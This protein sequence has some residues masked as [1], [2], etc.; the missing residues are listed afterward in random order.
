M[1]TLR[2]GESKRDNLKVSLEHDRMCAR[3]TEIGIEE[4]VVPPCPP[5][6]KFIAS[7]GQ[8]DDGMKQASCPLCRLLAAICNAPVHRR[9]RAKNEYHLRAFQSIHAS[10][11]RI[12]PK[13]SI[14][15]PGV[16][17]G[18][19]RG[20]KTQIRTIERQRCLTKG[21]VAPS[22]YLSS[23]DCS[24]PQFDFQVQ[25][26]RPKVASFAQVKQWLDICHRTHNGACRKATSDRPSNFKCIDTNNCEN[27]LPE[28]I[29]ADDEYLALSY[30]CSEAC[31]RQYC[32]Q[33]TD[34]SPPQIVPHVCQTIKDA[35]AVT[36][37][38]GFRYIWI[39]KYCIDQHNHPERRAAIAT[40]DQIYEGASMTLVAAPLPDSRPGLPGISRER[41]TSQPTV[42]IGKYLWV[43]T[44]PH[45]S[46]AIASTTWVTRGW[47]Y[48]E[49]VLS[50]RCLFFTDEQM[51]F[52]CQQGIASESITTPPDMELPSLGLRSFRSYALNTDLT[53]PRQP[54]QGLWQFF[55]D[56]YHYKRRDLSFDFDS[57][58]AFQGVLT[59]YEYKHIWGT[60]IVDKSQE[61]PA[62]EDIDLR[63]SFLRGLWWENPGHRSYN[64][65]PTDHKHSSFQ[66]RP[67]FPSWSWP[68]WKGPISPHK[69]NSDLSSD[70]ACNAISEQTPE[71]HLWFETVGGSLK[72]IEQTIDD[73]TLEINHTLRIGTTVYK[74]RIRRPTGTDRLPHICGCYNDRVRCD[75]RHTVEQ[76]LRL[77]YDPYLLEPPEE[78]FEKDWYVIRLFTVDDRSAA[79]NPTI[80]A[81]IVDWDGDSDH[82]A[83]VI[84]VA[85]LELHSLPA[86]A[87]AIV[88]LN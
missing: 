8:I 25:E 37:S 26:V 81:F 50:T 44:L 88:K 57:L 4:T 54:P 67:Q 76:N 10:G 85:Y 64:S 40:M 73:A 3:C 28:L 32:Q 58:S 74:V 41:S 86:G 78:L 66:R 72:T 6:T 43:S 15:V 29:R 21:F 68:G 16:I 49:M 63:K 82:F 38:L 71:I 11:P 77:F 62:A 55:E 36:R 70:N 84:G 13:R 23:T 42:K 34:T 65:L 30:V 22:A 5:A 45:L 17:L 61:T 35:L 52:L 39:D 47:T 46:V 1:D 31:E 18:V 14:G 33:G 59:R 24:E 2:S 69:F 12:W 9:R 19:C 83:H 53:T 48:Q 79:S 80:A 20:S 51:Y 60:P 7:L 56:L 27:M 75:A 87:E